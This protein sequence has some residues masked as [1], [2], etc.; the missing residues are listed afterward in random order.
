VAV[1]AAAAAAADGEAVSARVEAVHALR[2]AG[3]PARAALP[4]L[5]RLW[6]DRGVPLPLRLAARRAVAALR[7]NSSR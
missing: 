5:L 2:A 1:L 4:A 7:G 6:E 3:A